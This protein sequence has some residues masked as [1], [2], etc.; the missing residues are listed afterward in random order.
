MLP[1]RKPATEAEDWPNRWDIGVDRKR[2]AAYVGLALFAGFIFG[3]L[4][5]RQLLSD[6]ADETTRLALSHK[7]RDVPATEP[8]VKADDF[9]RVT[10][11][12]RA[13]TV[14]VEGAGVVRMLGV[15]VPDD[16]PQYAAHV[17][18]ALAFTEALLA[19]QDVRLEFEEASAKDELGQTFAYIYTRDG[20]L[21]NGELVRQGHAFV[22]GGVLF[23]MADEFRALEREA[24]QAMRGLWGPDN[25]SDS[26]LAAAPTPAG[27]TSTSA[28][29]GNKPGRLT[30]ML[31]SE[32][33]PNLPALS[34]S[35]SSS[36]PTTGASAGEPAVLVSSADRLYHKSGCEYLSK[37]RRALPLSQARS[38]G[39]TACSRCYPST[40]M[41]AQ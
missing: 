10:R 12:I 41:R 19:G 26:S 14:E 7:E 30:P 5:A 2:V 32:I 11:I 21:V 35:G 31:P 8:V 16:K 38:E 17:K 36:S 29:Q 3:F 28:G 40:S 6:P 24:L 13:D 34:G 23:R 1:L 39:Y 18:N 9:R 22:N 27:Q 20:K 15:E 25:P 4:T 33:G 37:K